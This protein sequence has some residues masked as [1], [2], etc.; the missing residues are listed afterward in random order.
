MTKILKS[1][2]LLLCTVCLLASCQD[3]NDSNP[4]LKSPTTFHLNTPALSA[5]GIYD[6][7]KSDVVQLTCSQPDY[8]YPAVT[9][10]TVQVATKQD[11]SNAVEMPTTFTTTK[12]DVNAADLASTLTTLKLAE[13]V[14]EKNFPMDIPVYIRVKADQMTAMGNPIEGTQILSNIVTLNKVHLLFS[15]PPVLT[16][17]NI[18][19]LGNFNGWSWDTALS[20]VP[21]Y[22]T[23][24]VFWH[25][26]YIDDKGIKFNT[27]KAWDGNEVGFTKITVNPNSELADQIMASS[28]GNI[29]SNK[30]GWY[31]MIVECTVQGRDILYNVTFNK[32]NVYLQGPVTLSGGWDEMQPDAKFS[33]PETADG[34]FVS[35]AFAN[36]VS[37]D[38]GVRIYV[39]VPGYDW[40]KSE[41]MVFDG[42][43]AYRGKGGDQDRVSGATGQKVSLNFNQETGEI[44]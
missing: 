11:M 21:V 27:E 44:K 12:M 37:G 9:K 2:L 41:F 6:L 25:L 15:L 4:I 40:W 24:G 38:P 10:Y 13:G 35:P 32:P 36:S 43:I 18:Y 14:E 33:V 26:V 20:M 31:L 30:P 8:G 22:D 1:T 39:K 29:A 19:V 16:P 3:D 42:K 5:N 23:K 17:E 28:D 34:E 7:A